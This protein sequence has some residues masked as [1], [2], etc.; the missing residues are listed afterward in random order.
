MA[1]MMANTGSAQEIGG[2]AGDELC[3]TTEPGW[4]NPAQAGYV[5]P[6]TSGLAARLGIAIGWP[7]YGDPREKGGVGRC[8]CNGPSAGL[9]RQEQR[10]A[11]TQRREAKWCRSC[12]RVGF[13][14]GRQI[15]DFVGC[16]K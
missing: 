11:C 16:T 10:Q 13:A 4:M 5:A 9:K 6:V 1:A 3:V 8:R 15:P 7:P 12:R 2:T 14:P